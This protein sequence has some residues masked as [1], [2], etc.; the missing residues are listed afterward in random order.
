MFVNLHIPKTPK[1]RTLSNVSGWCKREMG[2]SAGNSASYKLVVL[3]PVQTPP[4]TQ[5]QPYLQSHRA[6]YNMLGNRPIVLTSESHFLM[7]L[8]GFI[9]SAK[10][11]LATHPLARKSTPRNNDNCE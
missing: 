11:P 5:H 3:L 1:L 2:P 7:I 8:T 6:L 10:I 9:D 4:Q